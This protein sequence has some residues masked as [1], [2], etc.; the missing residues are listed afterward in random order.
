MSLVLASGSASRKMLLTAAGVSFIADP[1]DLDEAALMRSLSRAGAEVMARSLAEQKAL[2]V[3]HRHP[4]KTVL[5]GDSVIAFGSEY[6][7]KCA[8][9]DE[10]RALLTRLSGHTHL[11]VSAAALARD[12]AL[13]WAHASPCRMT[14][15]VLSPQFLDEIQAGHARKMV[16]Q[17]DACGLVGS[18]GG[19]KLF[20]IGEC[21]H[22]KA[23][24]F[25]QG[26]GRGTHRL[27]VL[28]H[29]N[30][31]QSGVAQVH[32]RYRRPVARSLGR[33]PFSRYTYLCVGARGRTRIPRI[34]KV[35]SE[36]FTKRALRKVRA[37]AS[38]SA[39]S[40]YRS[41]DRDTN[42]RAPPD[43]KNERLRHQDYL[44]CRR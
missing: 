14:M 37:S 1:A 38:I 28:N 16:V 23:G 9:L 22:G 12:G 3:S 35:S 10:A 27:I 34:T 13:L 26:P 41:R 25:Q 42:F 19:K 17:D 11:L 29:E 44:H 20:G 6:L 15:R 39:V 8:S 18:A 7:S 36:C 4:G 32:L 40:C 33:E 31:A 24:R 30:Q 5:G 21:A 2:I 43:R